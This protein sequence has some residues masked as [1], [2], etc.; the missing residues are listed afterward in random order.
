MIF[1]GYPNLQTGNSGQEMFKA[2]K[3]DVTGSSNEAPTAC[4]ETL[5][6][7]PQGPPEGPA[8]GPA[9]QQGPGVLT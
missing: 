1:R 9:G 4:M 2:V 8:L 3:T 6:V 5:V 7:G